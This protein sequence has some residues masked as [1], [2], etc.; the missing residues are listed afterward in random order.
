MENDQMPPPRL[1][2]LFARSA[3]RAVIFRRGPT[4]WTQLILWNTKTDVFEYGQWFK[5]RIYERRSDLSPDGTKLVYFANKINQ[6]TL[7]DTE[8][9]YAWTAVS[10]PPYFTALALWPK[11]DCWH[12][13]GLFRNNK[14][15]FL[16]HKPD[17][18]VPHP[19]HL[20]RKLIVRS[21]PKAYGEDE[22]LFGMRLSRDGWE[23]QQEWNLS[24]EGSGYGY[25]TEQPEIRGLNHASKK[26]KILLERRI[27]HL[28]YQESFL[29]VN[30]NGE[31][32]VESNQANWVDWDQCGRLV[33][34]KSGKLY[35]GK[36]KLGDASWQLRELADFVSQTPE[37]IT[38]P[39]WATQW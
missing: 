30:R 5:G 38:A 9:T 4:D 33:I 11:G 34:L 21:N 19:E 35:V 15:L 32:V 24:T 16:N 26:Y 2:I 23:V 28:D 36:G 39:P 6:R 18:A 13:G 31:S 22:P 27:D 8:Y 12:G 25:V 20:P 3:P 7:E 1:Y 14:T 37:E 29:I 17:A 10:R